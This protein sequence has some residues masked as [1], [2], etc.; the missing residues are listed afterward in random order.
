MY[1][2]KSLIT[3][4]LFILFFALNNAHG[5]DKVRHSILA[6]SWY[7]ASYELL[8]KTVDEYL[9]KAE[10]ETDLADKKVFALISPHAGYRYSGQAAAYGYK[11]I[12]GNK[13]IKRGYGS[14]SEPSYWFQGIIRA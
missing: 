3:V 9:D 5:G 14:C 10:P 11:L 8:K 2:N 13:S 12:K 7:P 6:G 4:L 1:R